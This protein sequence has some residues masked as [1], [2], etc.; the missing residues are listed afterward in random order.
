MYRLADKVKELTFFT[1]LSKEFRSDL[2][3]WHLLIHHWN[4]LSLLHQPGDAEL[5]SYCIHT[6]TSG[7][8]RCGAIIGKHP[9]QWPWSEEWSTM[10]IM[11]KELAP[12]VLC[13]AIWGPI[14][15][16]CH[17]LFQCDNNSLVSAINKGSSKDPVVMRLLRSLW[18][19]VAVFDIK[20]CVEHI[21]GIGNCVADMLSRNNLA[22]FSVIS[23]GVPPTKTNTS[24]TAGDCLPQGTTLEYSQ[25]R[26]DLR[27]YY[28]T[29]A[30][31]GTWTT[32]TTGQMRYLRFCSENLRQPLPSTEHTLMLFV[33][34]L[35]TSRLAYSTIKVYLAAVRHLHVTYE[36]HTQFSI[37]L[38]PR[39]QQVLK[40]IKKSHAA[41]KKSAAHRLITLAIMIGI[42][43]FLLSQPQCHDNTMYWA[44]CC[45]T[46]FGFLRSSKFKVPAQDSYDPSA[47]LAPQDLAL[48]RR[49]ATKNIQVRIRRT[50]FVKE[51]IYTLVGP[52]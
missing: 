23:S 46:F 42:K 22:Q 29:G 30:A 50:P 21:G 47:H 9:L 4:G 25:L 12:I 5:L 19:F 40:G 14:L 34:D 15:A 43:K 36:K 2:Y 24:T 32:Y 49:S 18:F 10:G 11:A 52:T 17:V 45:L 31:S 16:K 27:N 51:R 6:D 7:T 8:W 28:A 13:C 38:T 44:A 20:N 1:R 33:T 39:L 26:A 37:Q 41:T 48:D 35:A 3:W